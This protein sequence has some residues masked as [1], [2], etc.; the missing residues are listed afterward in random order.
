MAVAGVLVLPAGAAVAEPPPVR[1]L[2]ANVGNINVAPGACNDQAV[3]LCLAPVEQ[4]LAARLAELQPD[5]V[6]LQEVLPAL[7]CDPPVKA[8]DFGTPPES[9]SLLNPQHL[10]SPGRRAEQPAPDQVDRLLPPAEWETRC[11][12]P[13]IDLAAPERV[14]PPWDCVSVRK[15]RGSIAQ[16]R[17]LPGSAPGVVPGETCDNGFTVNVATLRVDGAPLQ[18]TSAHPDSGGGRAGCRAEKLQRMFDALGG[19]R[20]SVPTVVAGDMN[21][22]PYRTTDA[23]TRVWDA[24][25]GAA[26]TTPY[27]YRSGI[28]EADPAPFTSSICGPSQEDP[29]GLVLDG[30]SVPAGPCVSTLDHVAATPDVTGPCDTLGE[31]PGDSARL[32]GGGGM[33]HRGIFCLLTV[34]GTAAPAPDAPA[35]EAGTGASLPA[36]GSGPAL[37]ATGPTAAPA[38]G[39]L[40]LATLAGALRRRR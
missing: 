24:F 2:Q 34:A 15:A 16:F 40:L 30:V 31:P 17:T 26:G 32:D 25:V 21:L 23:S 36:R 33:D 29:T 22:D 6:A 13:L 35:A 18:V 14:I 1:F 39:A 3:K 28:A 7:V 11:N 20:P 8:G 5:V 9:L 10:C 38:A 19:M 4:R 12:E 37:P 27:A